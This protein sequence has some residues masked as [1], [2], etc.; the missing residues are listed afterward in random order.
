MQYNEY[1]TAVRY[2]CELD[3]GSM[4]N[5]LPTEEEDLR[6]LPLHQTA[7][8]N[9]IDI[10]NK[11]VQNFCEIRLVS[12]LADPEIWHFPLTLLVVLTMLSHYRVSV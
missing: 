12:V 6:K 7:V 10:M 3:V 9:N 8:Q 2:N 11:T 5:T 1:V 4:H